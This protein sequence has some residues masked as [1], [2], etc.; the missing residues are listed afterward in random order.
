MS[1]SNRLHR[2]DMVVDP[3]NNLDGEFDTLLLV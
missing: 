2:E 3:V 1:V